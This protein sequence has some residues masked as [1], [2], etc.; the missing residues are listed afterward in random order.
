MCHCGVTPLYYMCGEFYRTLEADE[1][2][3]EPRLSCG[4]RCIKNV[5]FFFCFVLV[6]N[7]FLFYSIHVVI[8]VQ[9]YVI[10]AIAQILIHVE[11]R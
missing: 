10:R 1:K 5:S 8:V 6:H 3:L 7:W 2:I 4:N 11:R 9:I